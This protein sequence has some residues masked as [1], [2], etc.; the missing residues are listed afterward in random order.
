[1]SKQNEAH[2]PA[3]SPDT[4]P[5]LVPN[6]RNRRPG[7]WREARRG[8]WLAVALVAAFGAG[9]GKGAKDTADSWIP[10]QG[11]SLTGASQSFSLLSTPEGNR[12]VDAKPV[13]PAK[14]AARTYKPNLKPYETLE[15]VRRAIR[16]KFVR[17]Q[18]SDEELTYG[19]VRGMLRGLGD[20][21]TRFM[22][23]DDY[24]KFNEENN[25]EF[26]GIGARIDIKEDYQGGPAAKPLNAS[27]PY[28]VEPIDGG[29][30]QKAGLQKDDVIL[31]IDGKS[32]ADMS[33]EAVV[34]RIRGERGT[35]VKL[36]IE[37]KTKAAALNRDAVYRVLDLNLVRDVIELHPVK[38]EWLPGRVAWLK[39]DEFNRKS[40]AEVVTA[41]KQVKSGLQGQ[42]TRGLILDLRD[43]PGG[44][45]DQAVD[46]TSHFVQS[47]PVV[48]TKERTGQ[49]IPLNA[50]RSQYLDLKMPVVVLVNNYSAS[51]SEIVSGALKDKG[52]A[53]IVGEQSYGKASVQELVELKNGGALVITTAKYL[54][55]LKRDISDKGITPD[56]VVKASEEDEKTGRGAQLNKAVEIIGQKNAALVQKANPGARADAS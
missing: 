12:L 52:I 39:L 42:P 13:A 35:P 11:W 28:I 27:R 50:D 53:T 3:S 22:T 54:T 31:E 2:S 34:S 10:P 5:H 25:A 18:V 48:F 1:M 23:P 47:G 24:K 17:T 6:S 4:S 16:D 55:P 14:P 49:T 32:T 56:V 20:R 26:V 15:E 29:P 38:L 44:L 40:N 33:D 30:A 21:F 46:I 45:L 51:A 36:K 8:A 7:P 19:A 9:Y 43:N 41:L 37:R